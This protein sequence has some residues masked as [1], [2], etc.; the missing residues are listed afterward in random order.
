MTPPD[1]IPYATV[2]SGRTRLWAS[3]AI[4]FAGLALI[5]LGGCF[6]IGVLS[7][8]TYQYGFPTPALS[9]SSQFHFQVILLYSLAGACFLGAIVLL[10]LGL[11]GL[12]K[13]MGSG[14]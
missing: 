8:T 4:L 1:P 2:S 13:V 11:K 9:Q 6:L 12:F 3:T 14:G 5:V 10:V 7:I